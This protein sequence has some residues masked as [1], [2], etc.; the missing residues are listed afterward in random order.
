MMVMYLGLLTTSLRRVVLISKDFSLNALSTKLLRLPS[1]NVKAVA[2][3][4]V[5][6]NREV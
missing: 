3:G 4:S 2:S 5:A 1:A 6:Q